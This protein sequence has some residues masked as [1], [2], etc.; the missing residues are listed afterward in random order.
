MQLIPGRRPGQVTDRQPNY[1]AVALKEVYPSIDLRYY[2][3]RDNTINIGD[4]VFV[5]NFIFKGGHSP[6]YFEP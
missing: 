4:A 5:I 2:G 6:C 1:R 3:N